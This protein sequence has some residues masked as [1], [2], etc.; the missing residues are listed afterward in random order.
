MADRNPTSDAP[1]QLRLQRRFDAPVERVWRAWTDPQALTRWFG[2]AGTR[3]VLLAE[4]DVR[5]GGAYHIGFATE[6]GRE[7]YASGRYQEVEPQRRLVFTWAWRD[8]PEETSLITLEFTAA[9]TGTDL[10]FLQTPFVD[11][12]TR[13]GH[14]HGWSGAMDRLADHLAGLA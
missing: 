10:A 2:P 8:T 12:A 14:E 3:R 11:Q 13:D 7:H 9:G 1:I 4:T 5:A 6:D